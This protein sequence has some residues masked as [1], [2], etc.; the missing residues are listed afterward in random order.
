MID[1]R[2][3]QKKLGLT[4][5]GIAGRDTFGT[6][7]KVVAPTAKADIIASLANAC[8]VHLPEYGATDSPQR[9]A[10]LLAQTANETGGYTTFVENLNYSAAALVR[11]WPSR[12]TLASAGQ[13]AYK[14]ELIAQRA[15]GDR[16]GNKTLEEGWIF[17][18][19]GMLQLTGRANYEATDRR[20]GLG[21]DTN[22]D[23]AAVPALSLLIAL[24]FYRENKVWAAIDASDTDRARKITNGGSIGLDHVNALRKKLL[25]VLT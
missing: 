23:L 1:W 12:F 2:L 8:I 14:P 24:D 25:G 10:D 5:D 13:Y 21:L 3:V 18:G 11:V 4:Q 17:R 20:L 19:R 16:M 15:Y 9:L 22:P 6:L 7:L